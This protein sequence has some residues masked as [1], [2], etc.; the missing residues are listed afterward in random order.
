MIRLVIIEDEHLMAE[1]LAKTIVKVEPDAKIEAMLYSV[2]AAKDYFKQNEVP[3]LIFSDIQLGDGLS[4]DALGALDARVPV[5]F[6]TAYDE[7]ALSA[8]KANGIDYL[9]KPFSKK[10]VAEAL[11]KYKELKGDVTNNNLKKATELFKVRA[12]D[13][14]SVLV[15]VREKILPIK[16]KDVALFYIQNELTHLITFDRKLYCIQKPLDEL[17]GVTGSSFYR[18]NRQYLL[19]RAAVAD[20]TNYTNRKLLVNLSVTVIGTI[21]VSKEKSSDFLNWLSGI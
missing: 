9:L 13:D 11:L 12:A 14:A 4:F 21:T 1:D 19:N 18:A 15:Y 6:C 10:A 7:Y 17:E 3:N 5:I 2:K 16:V 20:V 8:F